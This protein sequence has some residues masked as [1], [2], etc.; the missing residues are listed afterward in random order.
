MRLGHGQ[1]YWRKESDW[2]VPGTRYAKWHLR[3]DGTVSTEAE[4][5]PEVQFAYAARVPPSCKSGESF[6][7]APFENDVE[8][9]GH[10]N[11]V[12][13][14]SANVPDADFVVILWAVNEDGSAVPYSHKGEPEPLAKGFLR[15]SHRQIGP[16]KSTPERP[17]HTHSREDIAPP[18]PNE[19]VQLDIEVL[20]AAARIRKGWRLRVDICPLKYQPNIPGYNPAQMREWYGEMHHN[21]GGVNAIHVGNGRPNYIVCPVVPLV[22][23]YRN[24]IQKG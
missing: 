11:A 22:A 3:S 20:P 24:L 21:D 4:N 9:A 7:S 16:L 23:D 1:W 17:W 2:P 19:V 8:F 10:F 14:I 13:S 15:A 18:Q 5:S 12:F 6:H